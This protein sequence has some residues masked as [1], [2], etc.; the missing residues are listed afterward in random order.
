MKL[1][2]VSPAPLYVDVKVFIFFGP[3]EKLIANN[4]KKA[5]AN[6]IITN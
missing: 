2:F 4:K 5:V 1:R 3:L 6:G